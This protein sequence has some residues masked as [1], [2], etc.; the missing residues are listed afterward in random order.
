METIK[1]ETTELKKIAEN[2]NV[3]VKQ[4]QEITL[5]LN[6]FIEERALLIQEFEEVSKLEITKEN[7]PTFKA[8]RLKFQKNRTQ[9]INNWHKTAKEIPLRMSQLIDAVKR[10]QIQINETHEEFLEKAEKHFE[11]LE[12]KRLEELQDQR[13]KM[14]SPYLKDACERNLSGMDSDVWNA[15]FKT[16]KQEYSDRILAEKQAE[17]ERIETERIDKLHESRKNSI[18]NLWKYI[19]ANL[20]NKNFGE[21]SEAAWD[22]IVK[23]LNEVDK[24]QKQK[25]AKILAD[26][27]RLEKEAEE[28]EKARLAE[29][30][31]IRIAEE[32]ERKGY[33]AKLKAE[34]EARE[35]TEKIERKKREKLESELRAKQEAE[36][37]EKQRLIDEELAKKKSEKAARLAPDKDKLISLAH[38]IMSTEIPELKSKEA[39]EIKNNVVELLSKIDSYI[40]D[41]VKNL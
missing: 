29:L 23:Q 4:A 36:Q 32:K 3:D 1:I 11:I 40:K 6:P 17:K 19:D 35:K 38:T 9:G 8:L 39:I 5:G 30:E 7:I 28:K 18:L 15:Y 2:C 14:I 24:K 37:K 21:Y 20:E 22:S 16:K 34:R 10:N 12:Q 13:V 27:R 31:K 41:K 33:E 25:Q 26:K